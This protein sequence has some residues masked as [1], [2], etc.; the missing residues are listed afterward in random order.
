MVTRKSWY[1]ENFE[2]INVKLSK[3]VVMSYEFLSPSF[4]LKKLKSQSQI[5]RQLGLCIL[6]SLR[7]Y[8]S[9]F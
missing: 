6:P 9:Y 7:L 2:L 5:F 1:L 4:S 3:C 8:R